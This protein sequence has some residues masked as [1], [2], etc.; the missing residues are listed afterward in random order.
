MNKYYHKAMLAAGYGKGSED[1]KK[2]NRLLKKENRKFKNDKKAQEKYGVV[3]N[4]LSS[5]TDS[6]GNEIES[7]A[8]DEDVEEK[9]LH[10]L[11]M[12]E[13]H[14]CLMELPKEDREFL[15]AIYQDG[16]SLRQVGRD[17]G[18]AH[19]TLLYRRDKLFKLLRKKMLGEDF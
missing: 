5:F 7:F 1:Y 13:F 16:G 18:I 8:L 2:V 11:E 4:Y 9:I 3:F 14:K 12:E 19:T 15:L 6:E 17:L 10:D